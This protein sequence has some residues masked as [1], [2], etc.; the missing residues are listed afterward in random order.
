[1]ETLVETQEKPK[2]LSEYNSEEFLSLIY[3]TDSD[4]ENLDLDTEL[5]TLITR[6]QHESTALEV[7]I[8]ENTKT[9]NP[10]VQRQLNDYKRTLEN[11]QTSIKNYEVYKELN[12]YHTEGGL[13]IESDSVE[14]LL[15]RYRD[16]KE[17]LES[18]E[19]TETTSAKSDIEDIMSVYHSKILEII[20]ET[21]IDHKYGFGS[22]EGRPMEI[23]FLNHLNTPD[24]QN[25]EFTRYKERLKATQQGNTRLLTDGQQATIEDDFKGSESEKVV[26]EELVEVPGVIATIDIPKFS[27]GDT[28]HKADTIAITIRPELRDSISYQEIQLALSKLIADYQTVLLEHIVNYGENSLVNPRSKI[29]GDIIRVNKDINLNDIDPELK[30]QGI[31]LSNVLQ[32]HK[33]QIKTQASEMSRASESYSTSKNAVDPDKVGFLAR[34]YHHPGDPQAEEFNRSHFQIAAQR[35]LGLKTQ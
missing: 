3:S 24:T 5:A 25:P 35:V 15:E 13:E 34:E 19:I 23:D 12:S 4:E 30:T 14:F 20:A 16:Y 18:V 9:A 11:I 31:N 17:L 21:K 26:T 29:L 32:M 2:D 33:I 22:A 7:L 10:R 1:M 28:R 6:K 8:S 27:I